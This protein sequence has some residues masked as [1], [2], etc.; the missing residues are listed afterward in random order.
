M[1]KVAPDRRLVLLRG[2]ARAHGR[3]QRVELRAMLDT[4]AQGEF[5]SP[6]LAKRLGATVEHGR[7]GVAVE[8]FG[9]ETPLTQRVRRVELALPGQHPDSLLSQ[10]FVTRWDFTISPGSL[11]D[12][13][14]LLLG[15]RF[16]RHFRLHLMFNEPCTIRLTAEDG[17]VTHVQEEQQREQRR[18]EHIEQEAQQV[19]ALQQ[20]TQKPLSQSQRRAI[21]REWRGG[22][23]WSAEQA[24]RAASERPDLVMSTEELEQLW[25]SAPAGTV[26][27]FTLLAQGFSDADDGGAV[28]LNRLAHGKESSSTAAAAEDDGSLLPPEERERAAQLV[29]QLTE[30]EFASVFPSELPAG[31]P[32]TR[33]TTPF[34][35]ELKPGTQPFGRYGPRM[36]VADTQEA[37]KM[38]K[39]L[40][41][42]GFIRPSR[43]PW[44]SPM[45]LVEKPDGGNRMVIDYRALN[46]ATQR[47]R[48]PLPRVDELFDQLQ[49]ARYF[50]KI[51]L[52]TGYWQIRV[53]A[54]DVPK[55]AFTSR[56]G[57]FE[58]LVLPMGLTN[59]PAEFMALM[60][61]TFRQELN[62]SVLVFLDDIL[63]YSRTL[64]EHERHLRVVLQRLQSQK[65]YA[66]L[67]KCQFMRQEVEFLG[68]YV[69]R[70]G[71][72]MVEGKVAAVQ[73]W[74]TPTCQ[75]E[76]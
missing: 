1:R 45:F 56:H 35:I 62:R 26:K 30:H 8:A 36:T 2:Y 74:P 48:Y 66:K 54:E 51:D 46:A 38:L 53:A 55:T 16:I 68:H 22:D 33:G 72:R 75:K 52:R 31:L 60:E 61:N 47:N 6:S 39:E 5:I 27:V 49:G 17:R 37:E 70:A 63:I 73:R 4:G 64:E 34:R 28:A 41:V 7:F 29:R 20:A 18:E 19:A 12:D 9:R 10:D 50:S 13:Y 76:V 44:G 25:Q 15:T 24:R 71:V 43:S 3:L 67:S 42:K 11:S 65:L 21:L 58:W 40:L 69:G 23:E 32:P 14:D 59:A 57:H